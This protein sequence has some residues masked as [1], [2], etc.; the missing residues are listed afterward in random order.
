M[1]V[2][3]LVERGKEEKTAATSPCQEPLV[4]VCGWFV[5]MSSTDPTGVRWTL[6]FI[7]ECRKIKKI[8]SNLELLKKKQIEMTD[9]F[10]LCV[11]LSV[12]L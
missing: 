5:Y 6:N 4:V 3:P 9:Q 7:R 11:L 10:V 12:R 8:H 1:L 2:L